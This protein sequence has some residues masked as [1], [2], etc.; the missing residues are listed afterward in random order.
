MKLDSMYRPAFGEEQK[1]FPTKLKKLD[2][3][4]SQT[5]PSRKS[6]EYDF[7]MK[8]VENQN[9]IFFSFDPF[10]NLLAVSGR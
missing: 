7:G 6:S 2:I 10:L 4:L 3:S 5:N 1:Y 9:G 8:F